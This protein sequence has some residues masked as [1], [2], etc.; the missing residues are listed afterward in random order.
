MVKPE[1]DIHA[2]IFFTIYLSYMFTFMH[3][4]RNKYDIYELTYLRCNKLQDLY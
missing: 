2:Y 1:T 3:K 4:A